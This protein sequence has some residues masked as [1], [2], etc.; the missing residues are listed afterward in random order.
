MRK[1]ASAQSLKVSCT[2][3]VFTDR[4]KGNGKELDPLGDQNLT[5]HSSRL[6]VRKLSMVLALQPDL[7]P[8]AAKYVLEII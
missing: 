8:S 6:F 3:K 5:M 1:E 4:L 2:F 7:I